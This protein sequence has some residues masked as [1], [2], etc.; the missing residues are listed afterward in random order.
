MK[1]LVTGGGGF[2][3]QY[4]VEQLVSRGDSVRAFVRREVP[5]L[6]ALGVECVGGD[7]RSAE[8]VVAACRGIDVVMHVA[9][10]ASIWGPWKHFYDINVIGTRNVLLG[11]QTHGVS[12]LVFT[13]SPS[14]TF[15][16]SH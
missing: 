15:A 7:L 2:L 5:L 3:G 14:V 9:A 4:I 8:S 16:G 1:V 11:C 6:R 13:S 12:G 10:V